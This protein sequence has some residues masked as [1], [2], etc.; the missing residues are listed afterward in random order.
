M[1]GIWTFINLIKNKQINYT[2][3]YNDF[4][5]IKHR[6]PDLSNYQLINNDI[7]IGFHRLAIM[8][9]TF[10]SNQPYILEDNDRTIIFLCNGE[11]YNFKELIKNHELDIN[12][13]SDCLVIPKL[14]IK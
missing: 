8:D 5:K 6:G 3:L 10:T 1:C 14:Y 13:N 7:I 12:N 4:M 9:P 11:I 2:K